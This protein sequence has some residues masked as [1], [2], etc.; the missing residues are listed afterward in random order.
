MGSCASHIIRYFLTKKLT[1]ILIIINDDKNCKNTEPWLKMFSFKILFTSFHLNYSSHS[2]WVSKPRIL[3]SCC[4]EAVRGRGWGQQR[5]IHFFGA[6]HN[7]SLENTYRYST[8]FFLKWPPKHINGNSSLVRFGTNSS[9]SLSR[10]KHDTKKCIWNCPVEEAKK[11]KCYKR[12]IY[13]QFAQISGLCGPQ[14]LS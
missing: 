8:F 2:A 11:M 7:S 6:L 3:S 4:F 10:N 14:F 12:L 13:K 9:F 1:A 5:L